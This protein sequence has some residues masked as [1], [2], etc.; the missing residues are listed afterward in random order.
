MVIRFAVR[1]K[2]GILLGLMT[3]MLFIPVQVF[4]ETGSIE[5]PEVSAIAQ[6]NAYEDFS[7][8]SDQQI[9]SSEQLS[10]VFIPPPQNTSQVS[11][12][13]NYRYTT[14]PPERGDHPQLRDIMKLAP[15]KLPYF[16]NY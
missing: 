4:A 12:Y 8:S 3:G 1:N 11:T 13:T 14:P 5:Q 16:V 6:K 10:T 15:A 2:V 9:Y 7:T